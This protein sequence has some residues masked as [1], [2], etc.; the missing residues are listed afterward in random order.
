M[1]KLE[2][3]MRRDKVTPNTIR[4]G[5]SD[6]HNIYLSKDEVASLGEPEY[7]RVTVEPLVK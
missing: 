1:E 3:R 6:R 5:D 7:V 4:Y 2:I